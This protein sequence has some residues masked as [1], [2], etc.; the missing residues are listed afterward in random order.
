M[1]TP[2]RHNAVGSKV[3]GARSA[4]M[5]WTHC[6]LLCALGCAVIPGCAGDD[7]SRSPCPEISILGDADD[8][9]RFDPGRGQDL[10]DVNY[11]AQ[12]LDLTYAC[13]VHAD[14]ER[15]TRSFVIAVAPLMEVVLGPANR[16]R[17]A[18][19]RYFVTIVDY[20]DRVVAK[21]SFDVALTFP[22][23]QTRLRFSD[24]DPPVSVELPIGGGAVPEDHRVFVGFELSPMELQFNRKRRT[25]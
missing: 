10:T 3:Q 22:D 20:K 16:D 25:S 15:G 17:S 6:V 8:L 18:K 9:T 14:R 13:G 12:L 19:F 4:V 1:T 2:Q 23:A 5:R 21:Q 7:F 24:D 11:E